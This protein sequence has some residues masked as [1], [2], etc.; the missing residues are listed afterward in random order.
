MLARMHRM[1][2]P[3]LAATAIAASAVLWPAATATAAAS[4][5][6]ILDDSGGRIGSYLNRYE[7]LRKSGQRVVIDGTCAS[8]C[9][10]LLGL[11]PHDRIC[12][13][14]RAVLAFHA[15]WDPS[16][17]GAQTN[18]AGTKYLWSRYPDGVRRWIARH[19]GLRSQTIYLG[20]RE[21]AAMFSSCR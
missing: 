16:L 9:T 13:T 1:A 17:T 12:V 2:L 14:P 15:A 10:L 11:I 21:L 8:A 4:A 3:C 20:G 6:R 7:A 5:E 19:G 18:A